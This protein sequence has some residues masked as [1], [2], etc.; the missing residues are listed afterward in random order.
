MGS[1]SQG[2][3]NKER[4]VESGFKITVKGGNR[5]FSAFLLDVDNTI[6]DVKL[7][8]YRSFVDTASEMGFP[9]MPFDRFVALRLSGASSRTIGAALLAG[10]EDRAKL[11]QFLKLRHSR[12]DR[13]ELFQ[14]DTLFPGVF[15]VLRRISSTGLPV[16]AATLRH[17]RTVLEPELKRLEILNFFSGFLTAGDIHRQADRPY[18]PE[19]K[20]LSYYKGLVLEEALNRYGLVPKKTVF[21]SDT[22]FD[23][24]AGNRLGTINIAVE[25]GYGDNSRLRELAHT[26]LTSIA[27]LPE[28]LDT[29]R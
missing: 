7:R 4:S 18:E 8:D 1:L 16:V 12:L 26:C 27:A 6:V 23:I 24:E 25:T 29:S 19:Y 13:P 17:D 15:D 20:T 9:T 11:D 2:K 14:L 10:T 22:E 5:P 3:A 21:V 28:I